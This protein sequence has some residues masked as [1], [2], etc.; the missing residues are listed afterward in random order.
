MPV[1]SKPAKLHGHWGLCDVRNC[2]HKA[3]MM[4]E[5]GSLLCDEHGGKKEKKDG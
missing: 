1:V 4:V 3:T 2:P 5:G